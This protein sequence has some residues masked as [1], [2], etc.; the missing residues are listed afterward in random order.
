MGGFYK[1]MIGLTINC[2]K[3]MLGTSLV[4][5]NILHTLVVQIDS[6]LNDKPLTLATSDFG[7]FQPLTPSLL[8]YGFRLE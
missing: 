8:I 7:D 4:S 2:L 3:K 6:I 5:L 1:R